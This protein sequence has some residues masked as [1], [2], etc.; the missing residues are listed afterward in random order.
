MSDSVL[1]DISNQAKIN[2]VHANAVVV[3]NIVEVV[4][5]VIKN[6]ATSDV[7]SALSEDGLSSDVLSNIVANRIKEH[8][9]NTGV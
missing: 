4:S 1:Q 2:H 5:S 8:T 7:S 9:I 3:A 6:I